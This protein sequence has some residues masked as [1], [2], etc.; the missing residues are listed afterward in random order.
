MQRKRFELNMVVW[1]A[2]YTDLF[3]QVT[4]PSL[5]APDNLPLL[6]ANGECSFSI[7]TREHDAA[8]MSRHPAFAELTS[9]MPVTCI[10]IGQ[11]L[12]EQS[13][14]FIMTT[15]HNRAISD[16]R[17]HDAYSV[18]IIPDH[19]YS[20]GSFKTVLEKVAAGYKGVLVLQIAANREAFVAEFL[21]DRPDGNG[22]ARSLP[23]RDLL[24]RWRRHRHPGSDFYF[25]DSRHFTN[26]SSC[27]LGWQGAGEA[28][29]VRSAQFTP[30][31]LYPETDFLLPTDG[32]T[33]YTLDTVLATHLIKDQSDVYIVDDS[34]NGIQVD[35]RPLDEGYAVTF[36]RPNIPMI[37]C[38]LRWFRQH[39]N[40]NATYMDREV[41]FHTEDF[42]AD[43][44][45]TRQHYADQYALV[46]KLA[47][48]ETS[49]QFVAR[50]RDYLAVKI[51]GRQVAVAGSGFFAE[52]TTEFMRQAGFDTVTI[53][54]TTSLGSNHYLLI[55]GELGNPEAV[56]FRLSVKGLQHDDDFM[57]TPFVY[58]QFRQMVPCRSSWK[59]WYHDYFLVA[60]ENGLSWT[61]RVIRSKLRKRL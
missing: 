59:S 16:A 19:V 37:A 14:W 48:A 32:N 53:P 5:L 24:K 9:L 49:E 4:L 45:L 42:G 41:W 61:L 60:R 15:C 20:D 23:P 21:A 35:M 1:G 40:G 2:V 27:I 44:A 3:L 10:D 17:A 36:D 12:S 43:H 26:E 18:F 54:D 47:N 30:L 34:D 13:A 33:I 11:Q 8:A 58:R 57:L 52:I 28:F 6:A 22:M 38:H 55:A 39:G 50:L 31:M 46:K 25:W 29:V 56:F 7:F 51:N